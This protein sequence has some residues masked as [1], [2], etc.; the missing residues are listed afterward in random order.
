ML[1][2]FVHRKNFSNYYLFSDSEIICREDFSNRLQTFSKNIDG[3]NIFF[4]LVLTEEW[5]SIITDKIT[6]ISNNDNNSFEKFYNKFYGP[7]NNCIFYFLFD[8]Y[9]FDETKDWELFCSSTQETAIMGCNKDIN[10]K[11]ID[12]VKPF[13]EYSYKEKLESIGEQ[14]KTEK[15]KIDFIRKLEKNYNFNK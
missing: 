13:E 9:A 2:E 11:L 5:D 15:Y 10:Q 1:P 3:E 6:K 4:E 12:I 14:F 8:F 7:G